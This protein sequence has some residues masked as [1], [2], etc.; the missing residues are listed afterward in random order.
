PQNR[1]MTAFF[2]QGRAIVV[3]IL[4]IIGSGATVFPSGAA[5]IAISCGAVG[6]EFELCRSGAEAWARQSGH[7]V[8]VVTAPNDS[9]ERLALYQQLLAAESPDIDVFQIDVIWPGI[10]A[11]QFIDL[12]P[13]TNGSEG[14]HL[15][16]LV[17]I[18]TID[19]ALKAMPW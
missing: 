14:E 12:R 5:E 4:G 13:Y 16:F 17:K 6:I 15:D 3:A 7:Q 10:L 9:N 18:E 2:R 11:K 8:K 19:C 1:G